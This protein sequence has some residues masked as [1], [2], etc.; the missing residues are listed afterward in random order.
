MK[1]YGSWRRTLARGLARVRQHAHI[2][3]AAYNLLGMSQLRP[4]YG[5]GASTDRGNGFF[6]SGTIAKSIKYRSRKHLQPGLYPLD[7]KHKDHFEAFC[8]RLLV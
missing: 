5:I 8:F 7:E 4:R 2:V 6:A 1:A 3:G